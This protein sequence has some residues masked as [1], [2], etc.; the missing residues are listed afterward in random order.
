MLRPNERKCA[1]AAIQEPLTCAKRHRRAAITRD[2]F[3]FRTQGLSRLHSTL[4]LIQ[5]LV[6]TLTLSY[7]LTVAIVKVGSLVFFHPSLKQQTESID[8]QCR[9]AVAPID[10]WQQPMGAMCRQM[11]SHSFIL[12]RQSV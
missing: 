5:C 3:E 1:L 12:N 7:Q 4:N 9:Y 2:E 10:R 11:I 8:G 6:N